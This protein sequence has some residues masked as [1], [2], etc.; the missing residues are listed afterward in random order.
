M[1]A[2]NHL[3]CEKTAISGANKFRLYKYA[4]YHA[5]KHPSAPRNDVPWG[6]DDYAPSGRRNR[7]DDNDPLIRKQAPPPMEETLF[8]LLLFHAT[9]DKPQKRPPQ[10]HKD[11]KVGAVHPN[12]ILSL[13]NQAGMLTCLFVIV[14]PNKKNIPCIGFQLRHILLLF[15]LRNCAASCLIPFQL[16]NHCRK[17]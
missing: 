14:N 2:Q 11:L 4:S 8:Q 7:G 9:T 6:N 1:T 12:H 3:I 15:Y 16:N 10:R 17:S 13:L 5:Q